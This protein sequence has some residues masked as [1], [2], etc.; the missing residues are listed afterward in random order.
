MKILQNTLKGLKARLVDNELEI[1]N[2][3]GELTRVKCLFNDPANENDILKF[4]Q[5]FKVSVPP[6]YRE[7]LLTHNGADLFG[8]YGGFFLLSIE[9][10]EKT[11]NNYEDRM[12]EGWYPVGYADGEMLLINSNNVD[13]NNRET[14]YLYWNS[15]DKQKLNSN[16]EIWFLRFVLSSGS[17]FWMWKYY[18]AENFYR[19][20]M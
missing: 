4:E 17:Y 16:F 3:L 7:F 6:D 5:K 10:I 11:L 9:E 8:T 19:L 20:N 12:P 14:N 15:E 13:V 18:S 1:Q 2:P